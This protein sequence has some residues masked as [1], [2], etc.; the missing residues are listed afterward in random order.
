MVKNFICG[1]AV[2]IANI[3]PGVSGGTIIVILGLFDKLMESISNIFKVKISLKERLKSLWFV[4][5][6]LLGAAVGVVG[7]AKLLNILFVK[8]EL[9]TIALFA[10]L[11]VLSIPMLRK[12]EM[13][14]KKINYIYFVLGLL[15]IGIIAYL[16]PGEEGNIVEIQELLNKDLTTLYLGLLIVLGMIAG[17]TMIFPGVSGSM[18]LLVLGWYHLFKGYVSNV[19]AFDIKILVPL[20]F[21]GIGVGIGIIL[22]AKFTNYLLKKHKNNTLSFILGLI[23][24]SAIVIIPTDTSLYTLFNI[25][26]AI[27][28]FIIGGGLIYL[29]EKSKQNKSTDQKKETL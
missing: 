9:Q 11:I 29:L 16:S 5:Q 14:G 15:S 7:F 10:G 8:F 19:T 23:L 25:I 2:G 4:V 22:S 13:N 3:I 26:T 18:V 6:I 12:Q 1:I 20:V 17:A 27:T 24:M 21:I 28:A